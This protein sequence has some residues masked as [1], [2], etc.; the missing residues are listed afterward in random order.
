[1]QRGMKKKKRRPG[2]TKTTHNGSSHAQ[3]ASYKVNFTSPFVPSALLYTH[4][5]IYKLI[6]MLT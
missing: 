2:P 1:M 4:L 6:F 5:V 3:I